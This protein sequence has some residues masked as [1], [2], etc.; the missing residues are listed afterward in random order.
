VKPSDIEVGYRYLTRYDRRP[1][2][3]VNVYLGRTLAGTT[4]HWRREGLPR[5]EGTCSLKHFCSW[6]QMKLAPDEAVPPDPWG[7]DQRRQARLEKERRWSQYEVDAWRRTGHWC[8]I[9]RHPSH[10]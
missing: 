7:S 2:V 10:Y 1:R 9:G 5:R 6:A 3:V 4:V 8:G